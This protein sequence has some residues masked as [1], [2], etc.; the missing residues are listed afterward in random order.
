MFALIRMD[1]TLQRR[2]LLF[3]SPIFL[4]YLA[5]GASAPTQLIGATFLLAIFASLM[6][7]FP[8]LGP[9]THEPF[10]WALPVSLAHIVAARYVSSLIGLAVALALPLLLAWALHAGGVGP[11]R[12]TPM[13]EMALGVALVGFTFVTV[14]CLYFPFHFLLGGPKAIAWFLGSGLAL[15]ILVVIWKGWDSF[16]YL[17]AFFN[18]GSTF[19]DSGTKALSALLGVTALGTVSLG[20]S[21]AFY[22][23]RASEPTLTPRARV[24]LMLGVTALFLGA[25]VLGWAPRRNAL[26]ALLAPCFPSGKPGAAVLVIRDGRAV[27]RKGYGLA[28]LKRGVACPVDGV[29]R[30]GS[31]TKPFTAA[32]VL[33]EVE[34][35]KIRLDEPI[36]TYVPEVPQAWAKVTVAQCLSHTGGIPNYTDTKEF[37]A[38]MGQKLT[39]SQILETY[40]ASRPLDFEPGTRWR[41]SN[42]GYVLLGM[43]LE[44]VTGEPYGRLLEE[45]IC[46][47]LGLAH[48]RLGPGH[49]LVQGY[50]DHDQPVMG[51]DSTQAFSAGGIESTVDDL[52][53]WT[54]ALFGGRVL[55]PES[56]VRMTT[57]VRTRDALCTG[58]GFGF[59][60]SGEGADRVVSCAGRINGFSSFLAAAPAKKAVLVV[61]SNSD[62]APKVP[63]G[64]LMDV[65]FGLKPPVRTPVILE[66][67]A[68]DAVTGAYTVE[69]G[70]K[71][72]LR[73]KIWR[74]MGTLKVQV[75]GQEA[76]ELVP[77]STTRFFFKG[78]DATLDF[79]IGPAGKA[80]GLVLEQGGRQEP[81]WRDP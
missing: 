60:I 21:V 9:I 64:H 28:D 4:V 25:A 14:L 15:G 35:G 47:H 62:E 80:V 76:L 18:L 67:P 36:R 61:L 81:G 65:A 53:A 34:A 49:T 71:E 69:A 6:P 56:L 57:P 40:V 70:L 59:G 39:P 43:A 48:T 24:L 3:A 26:N 77:E 42:T 75:A 31:L 30:I 72:P 27:L 46:R 79:R 11:F 52:A 51:F 20:L 19:M 16:G 13:A 55:K 78:A 63:L 22:R 74:D 50:G 2:S 41:Y 29:F 1:W 54:Q 17:Q 7:I 8:Y 10:L 45:R 73:L 44:Q 37:L 12:G 68:L 66:V 33:M 38:R 5:G 32:L 58:Y 23:R